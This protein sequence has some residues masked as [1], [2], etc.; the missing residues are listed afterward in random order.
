MLPKITTELCGVACRQTRAVVLTGEVDGWASGH[1]PCG[2]DHVVAVVVMAFDVIKINGFCH[3]RPLI[4][5][6][7]VIRNIRESLQA[8]G[9]CT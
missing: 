9:D 6:A 3:A 1:N 7:H 5:L 2:V 4:Q 8:F